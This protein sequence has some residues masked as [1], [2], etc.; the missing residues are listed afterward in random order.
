[1]TTDLETLRE[2]IRARQSERASIADAPAALSEAKARLVD[3]LRQ[4]AEAVRTITGIRATTDPASA[5][6]AR[7]RAD[8][9]VDLAPLLVL[10]IG[11]DRVAKPLLSAL[12]GLNLPEGMPT[13][14]RAA[15]LATL[16]ADLDALE[17]AEEREVCRLESAG[18][19]VVRRPDARPE[20]VLALADAEGAAT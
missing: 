16:N 2:T 8:G 3:T 6:L 10:L 1:M 12:D 4:S 7:V 19:R 17:R 13:A 20:I 18:Q 9:Y 5:L 14:E 15:A 11:V